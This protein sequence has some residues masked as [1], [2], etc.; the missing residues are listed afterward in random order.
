MGVPGLVAWLYNNHKKSNFILNN[1]FISNNNLNNNIY[2]NKVDY[3]FID[4][5][6]LIHP[7]AK[8]I[9]SDNNNLVDNNLD[10]LEKKIIK[11][12]INYIELLIDKTKPDKLIYI[13]IDGVAP[14][15]KIKH[16]RLRRFKTVYDRK[17]YENIANKHNIY[18][19]KEWNTSAI[20]PGTIFMDKLTIQLNN[21]IHKN[22][23]NCKI[24][25]S[26]CYTPGEG[27][28]KIL[29]YIKNLSSKDENIVIYG[30][31][32]D[33]LF[34]SLASGQEN[35]FL[36]RETTILSK[37]D[38][39]ENE[40]EEFG[41]LSIKI[42][43]KIIY[44]EIIILKNINKWNADNLINDFVFLCYFC[45]NDFL[46]TIPSLTLKPH[47]HKLIN[48][49]DTIITTYKNIMSIVNDKTEVYQYLINI[50]ND[51]ISINYNIFIKILDEL[52]EQE[53]A[54]YNDHF[55]Y[56]RY[57]N[58]SKL[59]NQY[60]IE[61][62][63]YDNNIINNYK[64][65]IDLG[66]PE[67]N[68]NDWK[69]NY[70][71]NYYNIK[72]NIDN[73]DD[74]SLDEVLENYINGLIWTLYYYYD[75]C[76][77]YEWF[78]EYHH[79]PFISDLNNYIKKNPDIIKH[80]EKIYSLKGIWFENQIKPLQQLL[81][82]LPHESS[83]LLPLS[84]RNLMFNNKLLDYFPNKITNLYNDYLYKNKAWQ[85]ILMLKIIP[86]RKILKLTSYI[87]EEFDRNKLCKEFIKNI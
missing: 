63:N 51:K 19:N 75:K 49:I 11:Q 84:Y 62:Y 41:Y 72:I 20:T 28:H 69:Y 76:K 26:S 24:I 65:Y 17:N 32:A 83:Y 50:E 67:T 16:Q 30:L 78:Y 34:L 60:E 18:R 80:Y 4:T 43:K 8:N 31:D 61:L 77:N 39:S 86:A 40:I 87:N 5:N 45:G 3:L 55:K 47:N 54:Y 23:F 29:Q 1:L 85:N 74:K 36:M 71:K 64:D 12:I 79:G 9:C 68:L 46:P 7:Q 59:D 56:K 21:W 6:C 66:N 82:V 14:M 81:L 35:I 58:Y 2:I 27:E 52:S 22:N 53:T 13:A 73:S 25:F 33:L 48:G 37:R 10:L 44:E 15:A 70:Y 57:I 42:L 38:I